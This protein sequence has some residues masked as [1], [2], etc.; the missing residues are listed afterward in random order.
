M[1]LTCAEQGVHML[2]EK[3]LADTVDAAASLAAAAERAGVA[4]LVGHH[5]R[6]NPVIEKARDIVQGGGIG[7]LSTV[8]ALWLIRK[9]DDYFDVAWRRAPGGGPVLINLIHDIDDLR[10][11]CGEI[12]SVQA[13][14]SNASRGF[15]VEDTAA[16]TMRF[17]GGALGTATISD[18]VPAPWSWEISSGESPMYPQ[19]PENCY[20]FGGTEGSLSVPRLEL[21]RYP[22]EQSWTAP[23]VKKTIEVAA[24]DPLA[25]Q[26]RHFCRVIRREE[27]PRITGIDATRTLAATLAVKRAAASGAAVAV[28]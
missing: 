25:R 27:A 1:G 2:V 20:L 18:A 11:I 21:W 15:A 19:R 28:E 14:I 13:F 26:L 8:V 10:F 3:P 12:E 24:E 23:L 9:P 16:I 4:L 22:H 6:Y 17:A 7:K 5:R